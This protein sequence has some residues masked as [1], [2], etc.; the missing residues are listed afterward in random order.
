GLDLPS[1]GCSGL[2]PIIFALCLNGNACLALGDAFQYR[3]A[4]EVEWIRHYRRVLAR[5]LVWMATIFLFYLTPYQ[6]ITRLYFPEHPAYA[7]AF[8]K[9]LEKPQDPDRKKAW[10]QEKARLKSAL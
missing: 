8:G 7:E 1:S 4:T 5:S 2:R 3:L 6:K 10:Q 9:Y